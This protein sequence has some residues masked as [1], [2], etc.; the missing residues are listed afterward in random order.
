[1]VAARK[2]KREDACCMSDHVTIGDGVIVGA[3]SGVPADIPAGEKMLGTPARPL[4]QA[5]RILLTEGHLPD[6]ARKVRDLERRLARLEGRDDAAK[7]D[8]E[9]TDG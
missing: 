8:D 7:A 3:Q 2:G 9:R 5:K 1:M 4:T 6:I